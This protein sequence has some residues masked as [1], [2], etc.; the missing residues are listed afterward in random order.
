[1]AEEVLPAL[2]LSRRL[3]PSGFSLTEKSSHFLFLLPSLSF[4]RCKT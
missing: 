2:E 1:V 4:H 3:F